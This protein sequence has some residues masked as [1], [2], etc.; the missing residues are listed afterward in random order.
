MTKPDTQPMRVL[1]LNYEYPPLGGGAANATAHILREFATQPDMEV[2][3]VTSSI[4]APEQRVLSENVRI[5][6]L[7]IGK[8]G[9]L[10][11]QSQRDL[12]VYSWKAL[13]YARGLTRAKSYD[14]CHAFFGIPCGYIA[15]RLNLPYIVSLRGSDVPGFNERF[16]VPEALFLTGLSRRVWR[17]AA[18]VI[19][20]SAGLRQLALETAPSQAIDIIE[21]G[22][23]CETYRP[24]PVP[25]EG[26]RALCV[27]RL[28]SRKGI[29][30]AV[31]AIALMKQ[32]HA[33]L[34][35]CGT[36]DQEFHLKRLCGNLGLND[37]VTF[38][39]HLE[40]E[41]LVRAYQSHDVMVLP[42]KHEG[43]SNAA[44]EAMACGLPVLM[45]DT[46]GA[47]E[48]LVNDRNGLLLRDRT[49]EDIA[50]NLTLYAHDPDRVR[51]HGV[52]ARATAESKSWRTVAEAYVGA[53]HDIAG[54]NG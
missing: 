20:N 49:P 44:L 27:S 39:G 54:R 24:G 25:G 23:D 4:G 28:T 29:D 30:L 21:N 40:K 45:S 51:R 1:M 15:S 16:R 34:T 14:L 46:G 10:S 38:L 6:L 32:E 43:M 31:R 36:G 17:R 2:D 22:V 3:L 33:T 37:R 8:R 50:A 35:I 11:F 13:R 47:R 53:Y 19:A 48:L 41:A 52:A 7:D 5:H 42:S 26:L 12:L 18:R 9:N